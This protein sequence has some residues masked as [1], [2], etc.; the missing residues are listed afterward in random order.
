MKLADLHCDTPYELYHKKQSL[1]KNDLHISLE[2]AGF[3]QKYIQ[4]CA[5]WSDSRLTSQQAWD[6][7]LKISANF[8]AE[9]KNLL[10]TSKLNKS[11]SLILSV[12]DLKLIENDIAKIDALHNAGVRFATLTWKGISVIGGA[13]DTDLGLTNFGHE[14]IEK[15]C[16]CRITPDVSHG[17]VKL[18]DD[19][20]KY[21]HKPVCATHSNAYAVYP[22]KRNIADHHAKM[23][24]QKGGL[25]GA[26]LCPMHINGDAPDI[27]RYIDHIEHLISVAGTD[28]IVLGC[29][30]DGVSSLPE[31]VRDITSTEYIF[32]ALVRRIG[33]TN[34][35][36]VFFDNIY[37]FIQSNVLG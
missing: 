30:F 7:F 11:I 17:S 20:L 12:E 2:K 29:D 35:E 37:N 6:D 5:V 34:A 23:I 24:A 15:L 31:G 10:C 18:I 3:L 21:A 28:S 1:L 33:N 16:E 27:Y 13:W 14:V 32:E 8:K 19:V 4:I 9:A 36:K 22:H 26:S 25:I